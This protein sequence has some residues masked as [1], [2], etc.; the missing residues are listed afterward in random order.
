MCEKVRAVKPSVSIVNVAGYEYISG[1]NFSRRRVKAGD[2]VGIGG[3]NEDEATSHQD[4]GPFVT[5]TF[6]GQPL[7]QPQPGS[8]CKSLHQY[9]PSHLT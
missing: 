5:S 4:Q 6:S 8:T 3:C 2:R 1:A 9:G 7:P